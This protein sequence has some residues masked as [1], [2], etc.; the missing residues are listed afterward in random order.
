L[1]H[2]ENPREESKEHFMAKLNLFNELRGLVSLWSPHPNPHQWPTPP[3]VYSAYME[4]P[5]PQRFYHKKDFSWAKLAAAK[6]CRPHHFMQE[7]RNV[8]PLPSRSEELYGPR[9]FVFDIA[10]EGARGLMGAIEVVH[11]A[12][13]TE[14][15]KTWCRFYPIPL[16]VVTAEWLIKNFIGTD[17]MYLE[18]EDG[19]RAP[20]GPRLFDQSA[21]IR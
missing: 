17:L 4:Y 15:K 13:P 21:W 1:S 2:Q 18:L 10:V 12:Y 6:Q 19:R 9:C 8:V 7:N 3:P 20:W 14:G 5:V 16:L 11:T